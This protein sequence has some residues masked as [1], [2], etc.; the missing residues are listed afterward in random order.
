M[1][2][3]EAQSQ[4]SR[5]VGIV[6]DVLGRYI[7]KHGCPC[8]WS[9]FELWVSK[10]QSHGFQ[11]NFQN[12]LIK[13]ALELPCFSEHRFRPKPADSDFLVT[14]SR[15][16]S[17]WQYSSVE[18]RMCAYHERLIPLKSKVSSTGQVTQ[19]VGENLFGTAGF[20]L[21][22][23]TEILPLKEWAE[24]MLGE[25]YTLQVVDSASASVKP[26][27]NSV[28]QRITAWFSGRT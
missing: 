18:W 28:M 12:E 2:I 20:Q 7:S 10:P 15:C 4:Y 16:G 1:D 22:Q 23:G 21:P 11:D 14:C 13:A 9:Q 27:A 25:P 3:A 26:S 8:D 6:K 17:K 24:F 5:F 19:I